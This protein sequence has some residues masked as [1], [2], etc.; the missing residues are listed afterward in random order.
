MDDPGFMGFRRA[1]GRVGT[2]NHVLVL[3]VVGLVTAAAR[4]IARS[5]AGSLLIASP[6]GRGQFGADKVVHEKLLIGLGKNPNAASVLVI[7]AD[8]K[9]ADRVADGIASTRKPVEIATLDDVHEDSLRLSERGTRLAARL[10]RDASRLRRERCGIDAI[11]LGIECGHSDATSGLVANPVSGAAADRL[12]DAGGT[13]M[14]GET[15]EWL[16]AEKLLARRAVDAAVGEAIVGAVARREAAV[17]ATGH[18]LTGNNPGEEN[19]RGGISTIEEK[20][21]GGIAKGGTRVITGVLGLGEQPAK[22]GLH[23]MDAPAFSPESLTGFAASGCNLAFFT[24]GAG[25]SYCSALMPTIKISGR[26]DTIAELPHQIDFDA[27]A[28]FAGREDPSV[29]GARLFELVREI[30]S[31]TR[32]WGEILDEGD[33]S[34][35]R[36]GGSL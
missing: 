36:V 23:V 6:Y 4:R 15:I 21:L 27:S 8:R 35:A 11:A 17:A 26:P 2:R 30:A 10:V 12:V 28:V 18:D 29:A 1:D 7:G 33:E 22:T 16:G 19:I 31:G 9:T 25:N 34:F 13:A 20:S 14:F 24:T 3:S 32:S 5:V